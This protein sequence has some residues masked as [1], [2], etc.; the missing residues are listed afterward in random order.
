MLLSSAAIAANKPVVTFAGIADYMPYSY[1]Q[2][3]VPV[4]FY[5]D[6]VKKLFSKAGYSV[7]IKLVSTV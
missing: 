5:N 3:G 4:G 1:E 7:N 6:I 2:D